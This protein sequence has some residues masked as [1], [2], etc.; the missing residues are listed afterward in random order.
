MSKLCKYYVVSSGLTS[1]L[2]MCTSAPLPRLGAARTA[3]AD[4]NAGGNTRSTR[5]RHSQSLELE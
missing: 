4:A 2:H 3:K 5:L 1:T